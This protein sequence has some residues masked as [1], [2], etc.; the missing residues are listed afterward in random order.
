MRLLTARTL[1]GRPSLDVRSR[2]AALALIVLGVIGA[3]DSTSSGNGPGGTGTDSMSDEAGS[4]GPAVSPTSARPSDSIEPDAFD[5]TGIAWRFVAFG[6]GTVTPARPDGRFTLEIAGDGRSVSGEDGCGPWSSVAAL[7]EN[8]L[9]IDGRVERAVPTCG[10]SDAVRDERERI[11]ETMRRVGPRTGTPERLVLGGRDGPTLVFV[12]DGTDP[13]TERWTSLDPAEPPVRPLGFETLRA[14]PPRAVEPCDTVDRPPCGPPR[15]RV[16]VYREADAF[17]TAYDD[18]LSGFPVGLT[19][20]V[21]AVDFASSAVVGVLGDDP[22]GYAPSSIAVESV[23]DRGEE[24]VVELERDVSDEGCPLSS[25]G[26]VESLFVAVP[27]PAPD[28]RV[29]ERRI[30]CDPVEAVLGGG[31]SFTY[32]V[33]EEVLAG[34]DVPRLALDLEYRADNALVVALRPGANPSGV[35]ALRVRGNGGVARG[36]SADRVLL[37]Q[38]VPGLDHSFLISA[39]GADGAPVGRALLSVNLDVPRETVEP[40]TVPYEAVSYEA[41]FSTLAGREAAA[42]LEAGASSSSVEPNEACAARAVAG[43]DP[44]YAYTFRYLD[45]ETTEV[46]GRVR[47]AEGRTFLIS[48]ITGQL[49]P[50]APV[51]HECLELTLDGRGA[52][53]EDWFGALNPW[54]PLSGDIR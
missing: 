18:W 37:T 40:T 6:G 14:L 17:S 36:L 52:V 9:A 19:A 26:R 8:G 41:V 53:C 22:G 27:A 28:V 21:P 20:G 23:V 50:S 35:R 16:E 7:S 42:C 39:I 4:P 34:P 43:G 13:S 12:P 3:C 31:G 45:I 24:T 1:R 54:T 5:V 33:A 15:R 44:Y 47:D 38:L 10:A 46:R 2:R 25:E 32:G 11:Y 48:G 29:V 51:G 49:G 30:A